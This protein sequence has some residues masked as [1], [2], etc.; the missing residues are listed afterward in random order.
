MTPEF[1]EHDRRNYEAFRAAGGD[2]SH[3][4]HYTGE[5]AIK[6]T[7]IAGVLEAYEWPAGS[8]HP[9]KL[10]QWL[11]NAVIEKGVQL[12]THCPAI[13]V[14]S[15]SS[16]DSQIGQQ[17][18]LWDIKTPR[19]TVTTQK[20]VY[21]T[22]GFTGHLLPEL[23]SHIVPYRGQ[24]HAIIPVPALAGN[25]VM[26]STYSLRYSLNHYYSIIQRQSDGTIV[27]GC[28]LPNPELPR[29]VIEG[30]RTIDDSHFNKA[31]KEDALNH[32]K[33]LFPDAGLDDARYGEGLAH[34]WNGIVG[35]SSDEVPFLGPV[36][37]KPG[38]YVCGGF[39][40]HGMIPLLYRL[41]TT[42]TVNRYGK[43]IHLCA[44]CSPDDARQALG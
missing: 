18:P 43:N 34:V 9:A 12:Y 41:I 6:R 26:K 31:I 32:F 1:A 25:K 15:S 30:I 29:G 42:N 2:V 21:C 19:G 27:F 38:Q 11:L 14:T 17:A 22:N 23:A 28:S 33:A 7:G 40:G 4:K 24:A 20:V 35:L 13:S 39:N 5:E 3:V 44:W 16:S 10:A 8:S 36:E 37:G